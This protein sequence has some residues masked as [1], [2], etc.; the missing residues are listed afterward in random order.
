MIYLIFIA[1]ILKFALLSAH[2]ATLHNIPIPIKNTL[3][4]VPPADINGSGIPVGGIVPVTTATFIAVC[5]AIIAVIPVAKYTPSLS[6]ASCAIRIPM[7]TISK[8]ITISIM[9]PTS[10]NS[11]PIIEKIK[12]LSLNGK[13][14]YFCLLLNSPTPNS[15]PAPS[16]YSDC[17][18]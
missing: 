15:P 16:E 6:N 9:Q 18:N 14:M 1:F 4:L 5:T 10:P 12:S 7:Y 2:L 17:I 13:N 3:T 11:S 8:Y